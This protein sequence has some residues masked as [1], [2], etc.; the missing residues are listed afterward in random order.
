MAKITHTRRIT[1]EGPFLRPTRPN[2]HA[3]SVLLRRE[4]CIFGTRFREFFLQVLQGQQ[5]SIR[6]SHLSKKARSKHGGAEQTLAGSH[7]PVIM[8]ASDAVANFSSSDVS[9]KKTHLQGPDAFKIVELG[10]P[11]HMQT[12]TQSHLPCLGVAHARVVWSE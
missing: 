4:R 7:C 3:K 8:E 9:A 11:K 12:T 1:R 5:K 6:S 2:T 10:P